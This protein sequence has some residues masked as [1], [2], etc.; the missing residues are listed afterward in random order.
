MWA[1]SSTSAVPGHGADDKGVAVLADAGKIGH[2][3]EVDQLLGVG[4][5]QLHGSQQG[6]PASQGFAAG[7]SQFGSVSR[8]S[9]ALKGECIHGIAPDS[10]A[11]CGCRSGDSGSNLQDFAA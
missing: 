8:R 6:L 10:I 2:A 7:C 9:G 4:Q 11:D 1:A 3:G 5:A